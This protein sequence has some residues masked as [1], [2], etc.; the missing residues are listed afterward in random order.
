MDPAAG[1]ACKECVEEAAWIFSQWV[2]GVEPRVSEEPMG[3]S[4]VN[5]GNVTDTAGGAWSRKLALQRL[6]R[7]A[8]Y[9]SQATE[10]VKRASL[11]RPRVKRNDYQ[12][13]DIVYIYRV[14]KKPGGVGAR[15]QG[16]GQWIGPGTI[17]KEGDSIW[18]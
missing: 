5:N 16:V 3:E 11:G 4:V 10:A 1:G 13:G 15:H 12:T 14:V 2:F 18:V 8:F 7:V 9:E 6:A 17:G